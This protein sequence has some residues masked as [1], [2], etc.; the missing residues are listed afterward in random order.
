MPI[1]HKARGL[2]ASCTSSGHYLF[3]RYHHTPTRD[4][5]RGELDGREGDF[6]YEELGST[7]TADSWPGGSVPRS[8]CSPT[9]SPD[10]ATSTSDASG[11]N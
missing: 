9:T 6:P 5:E 4:I 10:P 7:V 2:L 3:G 8:D 11:T 1:I